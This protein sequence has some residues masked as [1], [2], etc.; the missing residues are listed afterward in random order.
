MPPKHPLLEVKLFPLIMD[1]LEQYSL[2]ATIRGAIV[3]LLFQVT[4]HPTKQNQPI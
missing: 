2:I 3:I 1:L 4:G